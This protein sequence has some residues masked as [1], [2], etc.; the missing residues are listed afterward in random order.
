MATKKRRVIHTQ[1]VMF[2]RS[3]VT[4]AVC[5]DGSIWRMAE[6]P[7]SDSNGWYQIESVPE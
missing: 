1:S 7:S 2:G 3:V 5:N 4:T 6:N